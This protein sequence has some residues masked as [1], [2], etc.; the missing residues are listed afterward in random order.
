MEI[1]PGTT[2]NTHNYITV[3][4]WGRGVYTADISAP[5]IPNLTPVQSLQL[6]I[7]I[8]KIDY[9]DPP[10]SGKL[11]ISPLNTDACRQLKNDIQ[12]LQNGIKD[13]EAVGR[14]IPTEDTLNIEGMAMEY[15]SKCVGPF[16]VG[17]TQQA[18]VRIINPLLSTNSPVFQNIMATTTPN[19]PFQI[20]NTTLNAA[21]TRL[22]I[23][24][25]A[26]TRGYSFPP[27]IHPAGAGPNSSPVSS[28]N[29][30]PP[31]VRTINIIYDSTTKL[32]TGDVTGHAGD[33]IHVVQIPA[34]SPLD[35]ERESPE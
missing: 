14:S 26:V 13:L 32:I 5:E 30:I 27:I 4:T 28:P 19:R 16:T 33:N 23:T 34:F 7:T 1:R 24:I 25:D 20:T 2:T 15:N 3:G 17:E 22:N 29:D 10:N 12:H 21:V 35:G 8:N 18:Q 9:H 6:S 11:R 31:V